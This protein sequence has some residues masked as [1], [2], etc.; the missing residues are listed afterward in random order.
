MDAEYARILDE[1]GRPP[2][3]VPGLF[4][5]TTVVS[6]NR[7]G[8]VTVDAGTKS[9][10]TNGPPPCVL[11]GAPAGSTYHF[12]GDE[13]GIIGMPPEAE[14]PPLGSRL[15]LGATHCDP[16]VNLHSAYHVVREDGVERWPILGRY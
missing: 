7:P 1:A 15:L 11:L 3:F 2:E 8:Q 12:A 10:A 4:V 13:H 16:T 9:L 14:P 5:L 6:A